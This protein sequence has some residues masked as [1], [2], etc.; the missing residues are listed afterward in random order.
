MLED[1]VRRRSH[2]DQ[3]HPL[4]EAVC[5]RR[6]VAECGFSLVKRSGFLGT[7]GLVT[8]LEIGKDVDEILRKRFLAHRVRNV[9]DQTRP[10]LGRRWFSD[11]ESGKVG[12]PVAAARRGRGEI[13]FAVAR[14]WNAGR[15]IPQPLRM[16]W[17]RPD[18][19]NHECADSWLQHR[20]QPSLTGPGTKPDVVRFSKGPVTRPIPRA[21]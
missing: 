8:W 20:L 6:D 21:S 7:D 15:R 12:F 2:L 16:H 14:A 11:P 18:R 5:N 13:R 19:G 9:G 3:R 4:G 1:L 17:E 10:K